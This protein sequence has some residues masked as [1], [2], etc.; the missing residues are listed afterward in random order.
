MIDV[1]PGRCGPQGPCEAM[2]HRIYDGVVKI[3]A[4]HVH[5]GGLRVRS[6]CPWCGGDTSTAVVATWQWAKLVPP[7]APKEPETPEA[8]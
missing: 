7:P 8:A 6:C 2:G 4:G 3:F 5:I 1:L